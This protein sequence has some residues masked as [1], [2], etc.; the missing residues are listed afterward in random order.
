MD[1]LVLQQLA[2]HG[3]L[4][5]GINLA[6]FLLVGPADAQGKRTGLG[7]D[8]ARMIASRLGVSFACVPF[9]SPRELADAVNRDVWDICLI[10]A[11][12]D[13]AQTI[14][15]TS[16][17]LEIDAT[18]LVRT[19]SPLVSAQVFDRTGVSIATAAGSA[20]ELWLTR[21][22][23]HAQLLRMPTHEHAYEAFAQGKV[24]ALAGLRPRLLLDEATLAGVRLLD[25]C[26]TSVQQAVGTHRQ[27]GAGAAFLER[28]V[29]EAK[30][31][32]TIDELIERHRVRGVRTAPLLS[33]SSR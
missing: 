28:F 19:A 10:G 22:L 26:F 23:R 6:N 29:E 17:Y 21:H 31:S 1:S 5:A 18:C 30:A 3:V 7:P 9:V 12:P 20:Y 16:A 24:D 4:R 15:F 2:P 27:H 25:G 13:R 11:E 33:S 14:A 32:G 8:F